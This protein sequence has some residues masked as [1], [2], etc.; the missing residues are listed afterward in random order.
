MRSHRFDTPGLVDLS[1]GIKSGSVHVQTWDNP[2]TVVEIDSS[3]QDFLDEITVECAPLGEG[4]RV[5]IKVPALSER[6][7]LRMF[8]RS[9]IDVH[10]RLPRQ[11]L[12]DASTSSGNITLVG[13]YR[14]VDASTASGEV[15][16]GDVSGPVSI[17][18]ASGGIAVSSVAGRATIRTAS[19]DVR[20][21]R[22]DV[23]GDVKTASGD[24]RIDSVTGRIAVT[25][26]SGDIELGA[27][28]DCK[29]RS[30]SGDLRCVAIREGTAD[31]QTASGDIAVAVVT[32]ALV[33]VDAESVTGD[34][35]SEIELSG[36]QPE[37]RPE[38]D[39]DR[40]IELILRT[41][42]GDIQ[43][44]RTTARATA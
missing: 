21:G 31:L 40:E 39:S 41:V 32:G 33:A 14:E 1:A 23:G 9:S 42:N 17:N 13:D 25:T 36:N 6:G 24:V 27:S 20:C 30:A 35:T 43:V 16:I 38:G 8:A 44:R 29:L 18:T 37:S 10:V 26:G 11:A 12:V 5:V 28:E 15:E 34:L 19:A 7:F 2:E 3:D 22:F 4:H